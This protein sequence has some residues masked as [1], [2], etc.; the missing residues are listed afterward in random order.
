MKIVC[1]D[2]IITGRTPHPQ[3]CR[4]D[5]HHSDP[6]DVSHTH[7]AP[8]V[9]LS[10]ISPEGNTATVTVTLDRFDLNGKVGAPEVTVTEKTPNAY[11]DLGNVPAISIP[12]TMASAR[13]LGEAL[14]ALA[15]QGSTEAAESPADK[16]DAP[17]RGD[18]PPECD[19]CGLPFHP[20]SSPNLFLCWACD[21]AEAGQ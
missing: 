1:R 17:L 11:G 14:L 21:E 18:D 8:P 19:R 12:L 3:W 16:I 9:E 6:G 5:Y 15:A 13:A 2:V 20:D 4:S 7:E 10:L